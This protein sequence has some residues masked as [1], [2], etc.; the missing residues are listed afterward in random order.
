MG[1]I[2]AKLHKNFQNTLRSR[3]FVLERKN[4][5]SSHF[6]HCIIIFEVRVEKSKD[7]DQNAFDQYRD[8]M[9]QKELESGPWIALQDAFKMLLE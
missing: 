5:N 8:T 2:A 4:W 7:D 9:A 1:E 6:N 3:F